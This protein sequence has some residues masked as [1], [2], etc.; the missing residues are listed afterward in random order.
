MALKPLARLGMSYLKQS[1]FHIHLFAYT[2]HISL[3]KGYLWAGMMV[4]TTN[5]GTEEAEAGGS[6]GIPA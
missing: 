5:A 2:S 4:S 3:F 1:D 6:L